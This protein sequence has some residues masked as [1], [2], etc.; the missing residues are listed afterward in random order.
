MLDEEIDRAILRQT[1]FEYVREEGIAREI[2]I[3]DIC[4]HTSKLLNQGLDGVKA[5]RSLIKNLQGLM[6][7]GHLPKDKR[8]PWTPFDK[9]DRV[10]TRGE[11][12]GI[13]EER[14]EQWK[15]QVPS[16]KEVRPYLLPRDKVD[17]TPNLTRVLKEVSKRIAAA[18]QQI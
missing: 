1:L 4:K 9:A 11:V 5:L 13:L 8:H 2:A 14:W 18:E 12:L 16:P 17:G 7:N 10:T 6:E 15:G 3:Q